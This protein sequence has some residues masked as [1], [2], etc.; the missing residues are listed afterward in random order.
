MTAFACEDRS[1]KVTSRL[2]QL[3]SWA[4]ERGKI[5]GVVE[6]VLQSQ[7][8]LNVFELALSHRAIKNTHMLV[9]QLV[10]KRLWT[11]FALE[12]S[13]VER[14]LGE[15]TDLSSLVGLTALVTIVLILQPLFEAITAVKSLAFPTLSLWLV[16][17]TEAH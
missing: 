10:L 9:L 16:D 11:V 13:S 4:L 12:I 15:S 1:L 14:V 2:C 17:Y 3:T 8:A 6:M 5:A 7:F